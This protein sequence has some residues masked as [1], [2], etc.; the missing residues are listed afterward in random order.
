MGHDMRRRKQMR[1]AG[2]RPALWRLAG[3]VLIGFG[4]QGCD[5][6]S[7]VGKAPEAGRTTQTAT[8]FPLR[9][10]VS[11]TDTIAKVNGK[12]V[13]R[14]DAEFIVQNIKAG[15]EANHQPWTPLSDDDMKQLLD[16]LVV[17]ELKA[18]DAVARGLDRDPDTQRRFLFLY[19]NF[20]AQEW[21]RW[22][23]NRVTVGQADIED[24]YKTNPQYFRE[25][26]QIRIRQLVVSSED[27]A[28]AAL[29]KLLEGMDFQ[30]L[31]EQSSIRPDA[32]KRPL[33][34]QWV[35]RAI[36]KA[37]YAPNDDQVRDLKDPV[38][39][40]AAF[41]MDKVGSTSS[42]V[43]GGD[44]NYHIFQLVE[45]R[46]GR[47]RPLLEV[48]ETIRFLLQQQRLNATVKE[49]ET[50]G[51]VERSPERLGGLAQ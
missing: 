39:E 20:Y 47:Q 45:R 7:A 22:Q 30:S 41:A 23:L 17:M 3:S 8:T 14:Q 2:V 46:V 28:K 51:Q 24:F 27:Q 33:V 35:M 10:S 16:G 32:A 11:P 48:T 50:K 4:L 49:L 38:L 21:D 19:R 36:D 6:I 12:A 42:Y 34:D 18:Q 1:G 25:P 26:E 29:V 44:G 15:M 31:A 9:P 40:Q 13:S 5:K 43:R 37:N